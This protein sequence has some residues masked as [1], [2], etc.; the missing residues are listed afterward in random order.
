MTSNEQAAR[1]QMFADKLNA[2]ANTVLTISQPMA[3]MIAA[4]MLEYFEKRKNYPVDTQSYYLKQLA[5]LRKQLPNAFPVT[6][7]ED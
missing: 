6:Y 1:D 3:E 7:N 2:P 4:A 5:E